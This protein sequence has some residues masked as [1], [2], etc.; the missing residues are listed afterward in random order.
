MA[1][2]VFALIAM[3]LGVAEILLV[4]QYGAEVASGLGIPL[5]ALQVMMIVRMLLA[6][7]A[8]VRSE[9]RA[10]PIEQ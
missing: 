1:D 7:F 9:A 2:L 10:E 3:A 4:N 8:R 6:E 5:I